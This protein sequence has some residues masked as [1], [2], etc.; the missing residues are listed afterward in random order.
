MKQ[1]KN[2]RVRR[3]PMEITRRPFLSTGADLSRSARLRLAQSR[4]CQL[5]SSQLDADLCGVVYERIRTVKST[6]GAGNV[7]F[8]KASCSP[9]ENNS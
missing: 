5:T 4:A 3:P 7:D 9:E 2:Q 6:E 8:A 1:K